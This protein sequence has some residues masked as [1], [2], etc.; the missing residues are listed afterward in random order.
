MKKVKILLL[1]LSFFAVSM[2]VYSQETSTWKEMDDFHTV[3]STS[4]HPSEE[5]NLQP[6]RE[7]SG[8]LLSK[9]KAWKNSS[10][11]QG[12][13]RK[14][15]RPILKRLVKQCS[16]IRDAVSDN[17][18]DAELKVMITEAHEIFHELKEKCRVTEEKK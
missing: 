11:P 18:P 6:V 10:V 2:A 14:I 7:K 4:F 17:K 1:M 15:T 8:E 9:A 3:M 16:V 12:Y 13:N 5:N